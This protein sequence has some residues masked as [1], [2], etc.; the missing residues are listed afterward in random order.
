MRYQVCWLLVSGDGEEG[1]YVAGGW[2]GQML[3]GAE[4][5]GDLYEA[6]TEFDLTKTQN[7]WVNNGQ[8]NLQ[9]LHI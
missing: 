4:S 7:F 5:F 2:G 9:Q 1:G 3:C 8:T 6:K